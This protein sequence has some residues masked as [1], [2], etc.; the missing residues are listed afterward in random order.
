M[1]MAA[2]CVFSAA[3]PLRAQTVVHVRTADLKTS[4]TAN[5]K[6]EPVRY[7]GYHGY[8]AYYG[9]PYRYRAYYGGYPSY[10]GAY[11]YPYYSNY[12]AYY[13]PAYYGP[14]YYGTY[15]TPNYYGYSYPTQYGPGVGISIGPFG[16]RVATRR[17]SFYW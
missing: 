2:G 15:Y 5:M 7:Y 14:T 11:S 4:D 17:G 3:T 9:A 8:H 13:G 16:G 10:Y 1:V 6:I 12:S